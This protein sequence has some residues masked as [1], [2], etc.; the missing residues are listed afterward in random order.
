MIRRDAWQRSLVALWFAQACEAAED[1]D[2]G[3]LVVTVEA[4]CQNLAEA[5]RPEGLP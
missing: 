2:W 5:Y 3:G 1:G 4:I